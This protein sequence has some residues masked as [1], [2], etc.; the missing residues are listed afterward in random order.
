MEV[1]RIMTWQEIADSF[2]GVFTNLSVA[3]IFELAI[4]FA[5]VFFV[6]KVLKDNNA[7]KLIG[8]YTA[9]IVLSAVI[10][11]A[12]GFGGEFFAVSLLLVSVFMLL[13]FSQ[14][15][16]RGIW[17]G[18]GVS[19]GKNTVTWS[20][21]ETEGCV[22]AIIKALQN[23]SKNNIGALVVLSNENIPK[24]ILQSGTMLDADI[25]QPLIEGIFYPKAPL[26]DGAMIIDEHQ[27]LAAGCVLPLTQ[28]N[29]KYPQDLGTRHRAGI[30]ITE[31]AN[32][33]SIIVSE[34]TGIISIVKQG[35]MTRYA[36]YAML[37]KVLEDYYW[38]EF[39]PQSQADR[40]RGRTEKTQDRT[41][42][43]QN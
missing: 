12:A 15:L 38:K 19:L 3:Y 33:I 35:K 22:E 13:L 30:G 18:G 11:I 34:E 17:G 14:E 39:E 4:I 26:H 36:D 23:M 6:M 21:P 7:K 25:S 16:K 37:R 20:K 2:I 41:G 40:P 24:S 27:I 1:Q 32:V 42:K 9:T 8:W 43:T 5:L 29:E 10:A 28:N 31:V